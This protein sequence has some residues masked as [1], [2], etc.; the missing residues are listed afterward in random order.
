MQFGNDAPPFVFCVFAQKG[1]RLKQFFGD[2]RLGLGPDRS[3]AGVA[4]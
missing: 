2:G 4:A 3:L 1:W